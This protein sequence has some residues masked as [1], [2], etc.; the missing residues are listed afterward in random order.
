[1]NTNRYEIKCT[2][3]ELVSE[4]PFEE[5]EEECSIL[6]RYPMVLSISNNFILRNI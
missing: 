6:L 2:R 1:M 3:G 5:E 4:L